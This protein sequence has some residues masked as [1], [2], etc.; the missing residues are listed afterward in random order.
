MLHGPGPSQCGPAAVPAG[1][2]YA[3]RPP[4][5]TWRSAALAAA[6]I[7]AAAL[8]AAA[9]AVVALAAAALAGSK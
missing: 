9:V 8:A 5:V 3:M 4:S 6:A 1:L 7:A 2:G